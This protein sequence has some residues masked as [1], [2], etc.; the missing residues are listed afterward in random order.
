MSGLVAWHDTNLL[1]PALHGV[2]LQTCHEQ[3]V[4]H[5]C[6]EVRQPQAQVRGEWSSLGRDYDGITDLRGTTPF[7]RGT[8]DSKDGGNTS[9]PRF[10]VGQ[11]AEGIQDSDLVTVHLGHECRPDGRCAESGVWVL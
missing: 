8:D 7:F 9:V 5:R 3:G 6:R 2:Y 1:L 10:H 4:R 11:Y